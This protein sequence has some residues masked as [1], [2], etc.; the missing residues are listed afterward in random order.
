MIVVIGLSVIFLTPSMIALPGAGFF[1]STRTTPL[2]SETK[3]VVVAPGALLWLK[4]GSWYRLVLIFSSWRLSPRCAALHRRRPHGRPAAW[5]AGR[6]AGR[7]GP[8]RWEPAGHTPRY[9]SPLR[10]RR[11][12]PQDQCAFHDAPPTCDEAK[13]AKSRMHGNSVPGRGQATACTR[14]WQPGGLGSDLREPRHL[15]G[16]AVDLQDVSAG[17]SRRHRQTRQRTVSPGAISRASSVEPLSVK[18]EIEE[19]SRR[20]VQVDA[21]FDATVLLVGLQPHGGAVV[22]DRHV[23]DQRL[24]LQKGPVGAPPAGVDPARERVPR[25]AVHSLRFLP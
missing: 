2:F 22:S 24:T 1:V 11:R 17:R 13:K 6:A 3:I 20:V 10:R 25:T 19:L 8:V 16:H 12:W 18:I 9:P 14:R 21:Q 23:H 4:I 15:R 5:P 7:G